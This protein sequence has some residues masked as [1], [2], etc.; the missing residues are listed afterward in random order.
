[1][2]TYIGLP[3][4]DDDN[5]LVLNGDHLAPLSL[6]LDLANHSPTGFAWGYGGSGPAQLSLAM[7]ADH[8]GDDA[9]ALRL[10]QR[11][12]SAIARLDMDERF[13]LTSAQIDEIIAG[14]LILTALSKGTE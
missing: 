8:F 11:F 5:V 13:E 6:R 10:Y 14:D 12:K 3:D 2:K 9:K 4:V 1:M 7:L